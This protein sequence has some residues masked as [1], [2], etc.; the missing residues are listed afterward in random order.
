MIT[1]E[2]SS[3]RLEGYETANKYEEM[4]IDIMTTIFTSDKRILV[5]E[6]TDLRGVELFKLANTMK[7]ILSEVGIEG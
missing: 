6:L 7:K 2:E 5:T 1:K 3:K 4:A